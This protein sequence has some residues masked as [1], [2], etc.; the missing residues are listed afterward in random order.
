MKNVVILGSTGSIGRMTLEVVRRLPDRFRVYGMAANTQV[1]VLREQCRSYG[2]VRAVLADAA[3]GGGQGAV[4]FPA[5]T[6]VEGGPEALVDLAADPRAHVVVNAM[7]GV[8]GFLPTR[9]ALRSGKRV[10][11]ANKEILV[12]FGQLMMEEVAAGPGELLPIDS[13]H[14]A[15]HQCLRCGAAGE[16]S[17]VFLTASG[18]PFLDTP[19][20]A[21]SSIS[22]GDALRHPVWSMGQKI[23]IDSATLMNK[24]LEVIEAHW[25]FGLEPQQIEVLIHPQS[26]I[27]SI[28]EFADGSMIAQLAVPDMRLPIQ[29]ALVYP[30]RI[31]SLASS[32]DL[33]S[34]GQLEFREPDLE[35][36]PCLALAYDALRAGGTVP[37]VLNAANDT[38]VASFLAGRIGFDTIPA[39]VSEAMRH[40]TNRLRPSYADVIEAD[41]WA[42]EFVTSRIE[43]RSQRPAD[44]K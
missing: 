23:T 41:R 40:H 31:P 2:S 32:C 16:V 22:P 28:V 18:G 6:T 14:S 44:A 11:L 42:R 25:L 24:G 19:R 27:H 20:E 26:M 9:E 12:T 7:A 3:A 17:R 1:D 34:V 13:E 43:D 21:F 15:I 10:G 30:E 39:M 33:I 37:A 5:D 35:R 29:Y 8:A 4:G 36:F 38:A